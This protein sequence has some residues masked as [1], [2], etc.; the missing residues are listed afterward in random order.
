MPVSCLK[1]SRKSSNSRKVWRQFA[2][3]V[4]SVPS[5]D[6]HVTLDA[7]PHLR[8]TNLLASPFV[9]L[10]SPL[11]V[12]TKMENSSQA[13]LEAELKRQREADTEATDLLA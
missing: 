1:N 7:T 13:R 3:S 8:K 5:A 12:C 4:A 9:K 10:R 6:D 2:A 11:G